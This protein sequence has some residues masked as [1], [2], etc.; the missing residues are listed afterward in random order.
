MK[1][2]GFLKECSVNARKYSDIFPRLVHLLSEDV[3]Y[4]FRNNEWRQLLIQ[5]IRSQ[6]NQSWL[7]NAYFHAHNRS[8]MVSRAASHRMHVST[9][10]S[11]RITVLSAS[12]FRNASSVWFRL[13]EKPSSMRYQTFLPPFSLIRAFGKQNARGNVSKNF[14]QS[15]VLLTDQIEIHQLQPLVWPPNLLYFAHG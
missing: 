4:N 5:L 7:V 1:H 9:T 13:H 10:K 14:R 3:V 12:V 11:D 6:N 2:S 8:R 15:C